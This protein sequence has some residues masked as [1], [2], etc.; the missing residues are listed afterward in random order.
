MLMVSGSSECLTDCKT[1]LATD[2]WP[3]PRLMASSIYCF[4]C[5]IRFCSASVWK[6]ENEAVSFVSGRG[7]KSIRGM[8]ASS[9]ED[10]IASVCVG[11]GV[12][13]S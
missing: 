4:P 9:L 5:R 11:Q 8:L 1:L 12:H 3:R 13:L 10:S 7:T 2:E 6:I